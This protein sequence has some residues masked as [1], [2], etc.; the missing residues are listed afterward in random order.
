MMANALS[1]K[2]IDS[3]I[4]RLALCGENQFEDKI[5]HLWNNAKTTKG[6]QDVVNHSSLDIWQ[7][8]LSVQFKQ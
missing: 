8:E 4:Y 1:F 2:D 5:G 7:K 3:V 6:N